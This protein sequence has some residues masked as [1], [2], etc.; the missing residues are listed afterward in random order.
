MAEE[1]MSSKIEDQLLMGDSVGTEI[2]KIIQVVF[3][4]T[5]KQLKIF[6]KLREIRSQ[7]SCVMKLETCLGS[8]RSIIQKHLKILINKK[9][10]SRESVTLSEFKE[11]CVETMERD[12]KVI[13]TTKKGY[14]YIYYPISDSEL[15]KEITTKLDAWK[16]TIQT[17]GKD[18]FKE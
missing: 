18:H 1:N 2:K 12:E 13:P 4:L 8:E 6:L 16:K 11:R 15:V 9:I 7:G 17:F 10:V 14:R 5:K 3:N